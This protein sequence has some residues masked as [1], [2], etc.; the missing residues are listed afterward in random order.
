MTTRNHLPGATYMKQEV[1]PRVLRE[2][3][4]LLDLLKGVLELC[5]GLGRVACSREAWACLR[6]GQHG[7]DKRGDGSGLFPQG[8]HPAPIHYSRFDPGPRRDG[9]AF[10]HS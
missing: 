2:R 10:A 6:V 5:Y 9:T 4:S 8:A 1:K 7:H 3:P